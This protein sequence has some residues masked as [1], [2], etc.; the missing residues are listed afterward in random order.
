[1]VACTRVDLQNILKVEQMRC[2]D[3]LIMEREE[4][5]MIPRYVT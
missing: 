4:E 3:R 1:M 2:A 5:R